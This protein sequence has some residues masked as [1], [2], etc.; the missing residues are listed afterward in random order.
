MRLC[1]KCGK[2]PLFAHMAVDQ[3]GAD[4][5]RLIII[6]SQQQFARDIGSPDERGMA[7]GLKFDVGNHPVTEID[8]Q[9]E[10]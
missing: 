4:A 3:I 6:F 8:E 1:G 2:I 7:I 10:R 9:I 5:Q